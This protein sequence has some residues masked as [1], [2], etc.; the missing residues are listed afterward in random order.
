MIHGCHLE[1][2]IFFSFHFYLVHEEGREIEYMCPRV[3]DLAHVQSHFSLSPRS[4]RM[5]SWL[6]VCSY[7]CPFLPIPAPNKPRPLPC[8]ICERNARVLLLPSAP[9]RSPGTD[10]GKPKVLS[11][12]VM[13]PLGAPQAG[14]SPTWN[15]RTMESLVD[16]S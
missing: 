5:V 9:G 11:S 16:N 12:W 15:G 8:H 1:I 14:F 10:L 13:Q 7:S 3:G 6:P 2:H 4:S